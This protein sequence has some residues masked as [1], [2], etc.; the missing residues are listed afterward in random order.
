MESVV[1]EID[2]GQHAVEKGKDRERDRWLPYP[3][4]QG[5]GRQKKISSIKRGKQK[6]MLPPREGKRVFTKVDK[7]LKF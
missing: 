4:H 3:S 7:N 5:R 6:D 1:V 2:G